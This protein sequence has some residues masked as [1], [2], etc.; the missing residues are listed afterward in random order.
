MS[1]RVCKD[2]YR[3]HML[4]F[5]YKWPP[6][7]VPI[8]RWNNLHHL[9]LKSDIMDAKPLVAFDAAGRIEHLRVKVDK[10]VSIKAGLLIWMCHLGGKSGGSQKKRDNS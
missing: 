1:V 2:V 10:A 4:A 5:L 8:H 9:F 6:F 7:N 3:L